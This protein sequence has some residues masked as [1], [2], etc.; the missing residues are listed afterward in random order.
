[1]VPDFRARFAAQQ[2]HRPE[3]EP[4]KWEQ[5]STGP[6]SQCATMPSW[7]HGTFFG[8]VASL[9]GAY[10]AGSRKEGRSPTMLIALRTGLRFRLAVAFAAFAALCF[11]APPAVLAFGHGA[12]TIHCL[13]HANLVHHGEP[14]SHDS[15]HHGDHSSPA[16]DHQMTCCGLFCLS[17]LAADFGVVER[18]ELSGVPAPTGAT[19]LFSREPERLD[20]PP[21][22]IPFV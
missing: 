16:G 19:S 9:T 10:G 15:H 11:V 1:M 2:Q 20:R 8:L 18:I 13:S 6:A 3:A 4:G 21:I 5:S 14:L 7:Q 17:A 12:N 22:F